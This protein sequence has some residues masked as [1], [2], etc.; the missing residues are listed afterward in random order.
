YA[1]DEAERERV[2]KDFKSRNLTIQRF[3]GLGEMNA[4]QLWETTMNPATRTLLR[5]D[6]EDAAEADRIFSTLMG[7]KVEPRRDFIRA[8]A[9][10]VQNL[11]V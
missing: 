5:A 2:I 8:R 7:E 9:R 4:D 10:Q 11:D 1:Q 6:I 3:K